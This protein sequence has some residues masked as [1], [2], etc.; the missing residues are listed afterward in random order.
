MSFIKR[1][2]DVLDRIN[3]LIETLCK[4]AACVLV[5]LIAAAVLVA[6]S[7]AMFLMHLW[8]GKKNCQNLR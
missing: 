1:L 7:C 6:L 3:G 5:C 8:N 2:I 4:F